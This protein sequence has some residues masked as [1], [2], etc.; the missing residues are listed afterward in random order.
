MDAFSG[1][2]GCGAA[3]PGEGAYISGTSEIVALIGGERG[4]APGVVS[5]LPVDG[6]HVQAGP[7]QSGGDTLR[8]LAELLGHAPGQALAA[9]AAAARGPEPA[10]FLPHLQGERAPLWDMDARGT[11]LG[12]TSDTGMPE[13]ALS[14]LEGVACS[15]RLVLQ[16]TERAAGRRFA[17]LHLGGGGARSDFW[18]QLRADVLGIPLQRVACLDTGVVGAAVMAGVGAGLFGSLAEGA[19]RLVRVERVFMPDPAQAV[20]Y[21]RMMARYVS[22]YE[23]LKP[24]YRPSLASRTHP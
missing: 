11:F 22:A 2:I 6:L 21:D 16:A 4:G 23:T 10:L 24:F 18:S 14:A 12:L 13:L 17:S 19:E 3:R 1:L 20:R 15:A 7:T 8:W 9:A 5:F